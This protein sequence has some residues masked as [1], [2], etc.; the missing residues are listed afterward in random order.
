MKGNMMWKVA[1]EVVVGSVG[2][3]ALPP[4][5]AVVDE[6]CIDEDPERGYSLALKNL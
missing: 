3:M 6:E 2:G 4:E 1:V 5:D